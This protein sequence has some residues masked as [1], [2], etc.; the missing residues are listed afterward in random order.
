MFFYGKEEVN[1]RY[2]CDFGLN[3]DHL[4]HLPD[5]GLRSS[6]RILTVRL[7]S[8][9]YPVDASTSQPS[10][11]QLNS[12]PERPHPLITAYVQA[13]IQA[14]DLSRDRDQRAAI[15]SMRFPHGSAV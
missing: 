10:L 15:N 12:S 7:E 2:Y 11:C 13:A 14:A 1:E 8:S 6:G 3:P 9:N 4:R 5:G